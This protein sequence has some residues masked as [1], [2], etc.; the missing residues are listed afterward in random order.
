MCVCV[1]VCVFLGGY[2]FGLYTLGLC[3]KA[4]T[5]HEDQPISSN[6]HVFCKK[7]CAEC[8]VSAGGFFP[9]NGGGWQGP[10]GPPP[11][12]QGHQSRGL[13]PHPGSCW[14]T[15]RPHT[16]PLGSLCQCS[17]THTAQKSSLVFRGSL[18]CAGLCPLPLAL[19][20]DITDKS[21]SPYYLH[22]P[23]RFSYTLVKSPLSLLFFSQNSS[24]SLSLSS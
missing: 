2:P 21:L 5:F 6:R 8:S 18:L 11:L 16:Q 12:H 7:P 19:V 24:R 15:S 23:F 22:P 10:L 13:G 1:C 4:N 20:L 3:L 9:Q 17:V 14:R